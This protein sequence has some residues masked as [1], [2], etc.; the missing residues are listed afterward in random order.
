MNPQYCPDALIIAGGEC[1]K[2][3]K[4]GTCSKQG[5]AP[6]GIWQCDSC[7]TPAN[8][9]NGTP[10]KSSKEGFI[11]ENCQLSLQ[12]PCINAWASVH[13]VI[14]PRLTYR[15]ESSNPGC[16]PYSSIEQETGGNIGRCNFQGPF[17]HYQ[18]NQTCKW[19]DGKCAE[20]ST[21][22]QSTGTAWTGGANTAQ[23]LGFPYYYHRI[24]LTN[25]YGTEWMHTHFPSL[26]DAN[27]NPQSG[28]PQ[29]DLSNLAQEA[30]DKATA[31]CNQVK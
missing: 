18:Y 14:I 13:T 9:V 16:Y 3:N 15:T 4:A 2:G 1:E 12:N 24:F 28:A 19:E 23:K 5:S 7:R 25:Y 31:I 30:M 29:R 10:C 8:N 21:P 17:C 6:S 22:T 26:V 27:G 11:G 20:Y